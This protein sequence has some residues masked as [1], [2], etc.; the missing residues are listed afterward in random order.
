M[1]VLHEAHNQHINQFSFVIR[2][3]NQYFELMVYSS[4]Q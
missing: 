4:Y 2:N 1:L 3:D